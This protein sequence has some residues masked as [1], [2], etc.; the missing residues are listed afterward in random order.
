[1]KF[2]PVDLGQLLAEITEVP[3][4]W[5]DERGQAVM[6]SMKQTI[7]ELKKLRRQVGTP[8]SSEGAAYQ[9]AYFFTTVSVTPEGY[10]LE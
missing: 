10:R 8:A 3:S 4:S 2:T 1:M 5:L 6:L 7:A 9:P